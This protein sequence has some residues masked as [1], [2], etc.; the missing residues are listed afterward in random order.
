MVLAVFFLLALDRLFKKAAWLWPAKKI[1]INSWLAFH[2]TTNKFIAFSL[3][4]PASNIFFL[5]F[6]LLIILLLI[7]WLIS[8]KKNQEYLTACC[9]LLVLAGATSNFWD[10]LV[11]GQVLDYIDVSFFTIFNLADAMIVAGILVILSQELA[12]IKKNRAN[13]T[14]GFKTK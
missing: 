5:L 1:T 7:I 11:Y 4:V 2:L 3:P 8:A 9:L 14:T 13:K 10:R 6:L 12:K